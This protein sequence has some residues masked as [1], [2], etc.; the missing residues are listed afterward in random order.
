[1]CQPEKDNVKYLHDVQNLGEMIMYLVTKTNEEGRQPEANRYSS[2]VLDF[3][4]QTASTSA[5]D[6]CQV[7]GSSI[8]LDM[9]DVA[10]HAMI[11]TPQPTKNLIWPVTY[12]MLTARHRILLPA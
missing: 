2:D 1:M 5:A 8:L 6:L 7:C 12:A 10:Q 9:S 3:V 11:K 4:S